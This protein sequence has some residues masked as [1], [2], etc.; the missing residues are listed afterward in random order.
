MKKH[1][2]CAGED[3]ICAICALGEELEDDDPCRYDGLR[4]EEECPGFECAEQ[5]RLCPADCEFLR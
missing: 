5:C 2:E 1:I 3:G 4:G